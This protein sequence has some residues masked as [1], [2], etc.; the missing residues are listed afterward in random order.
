MRLALTAWAHCEDP[1]GPTP[2]LHGRNTCSQ[3]AL[4]Q[5]S[6]ELFHRGRL[7]QLLGQRLDVLDGLMIATEKE[8]LARGKL[9]G[10]AEEKANP[11]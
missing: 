2:S 4:P 1:L 7:N 11:S 6:G 5:R 9:A 8:A 10:A 3:I